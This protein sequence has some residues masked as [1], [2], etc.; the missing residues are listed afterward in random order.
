MKLSLILCCVFAMVAQAT[1]QNAPKRDLVPD[2]E[3]AIGV[4]EAALIPVYGKKK[5]ESERPFT[6]HLK[7][8]VWMVAGT[9]YCGDGRPQ[10][11]KPPTCVGGV[12]VV[13]I[14]KVDGHVISMIH[15]K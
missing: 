4:A 10:S 15:Y 9:L 3:T 8:D 11:D 1:S 7:D 6:A 14:S 12:A 2:A 13:Q 5:V